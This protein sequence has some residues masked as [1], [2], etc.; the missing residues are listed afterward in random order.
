MLLAL[1]IILI[2]IV[3]AIAT[4]IIHCKNGE[5]EWAAKHGDGLRTA[6]PS[7]IVFIDLFFWEMQFILFVFT[8]IENTIDNYFKKKYTTEN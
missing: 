8:S 5:F 7:D 6:T 1:S 3:G 2:H 4:I